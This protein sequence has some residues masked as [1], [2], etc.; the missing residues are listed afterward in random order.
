MSPHHHY[1]HPLA[2]RLGGRAYCDPNEEVGCE[3]V[4]AASSARQSRI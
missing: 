3:Q 1:N 4:E 2:A